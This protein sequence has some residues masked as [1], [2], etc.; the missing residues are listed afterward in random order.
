MLPVSPLHFQIGFAAR[1]VSVPFPSMDHRRVYSH[2]FFARYV[3]LIARDIVTTRSQSANMAN[4]MDAQ[5]MTDAIADAIAQAFANL[6][7]PPPPP[8]ADT[9]VIADA[10]AQAFGNLPALAPPAA[11]AAAAAVVAAAPVVVPFARTPAGARTDLLDYENSSGDAKVFFTATK[12][13]KTSFTLNKPNV[14]VLMSEL[15]TRSSESSW[16]SLFMVA[17]NAVNHNFMN[18]YGRVTL[19][20]LRTHVGTF[21]DAGTRLEQNDHQLY[22]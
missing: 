8:A 12:A 6:P 16:G 17:V 1:D 18:S 19:Q 7:A 14:T 13:L 20:E 3:A 5:A 10:I 4:P 15:Q 9:Q 11:A 21:I 2:P 22:Q